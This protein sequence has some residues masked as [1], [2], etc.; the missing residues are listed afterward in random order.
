MDAIDKENEL[1]RFHFK[2]LRKQKQ[3]AML[4]RGIDRLA[5]EMTVCD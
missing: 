2:M 1:K 3:N 5:D 4:G